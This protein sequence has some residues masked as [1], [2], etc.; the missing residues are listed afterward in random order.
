MKRMLGVA[1]ACLLAV[2]A[3][4]QML[5]KNDKEP[6]KTK[7]WLDNFETAQKE[8]E[9][10]NQPILAFFTGS[11]WCGWCKKLRSEALDAKAFKT[12]AADNLIL[13]EADFPRGKKLSEKV[14]K[15]NSALAAKYE[16]RGYPTVFLL[17]AEGKQLGRTGYM[18]GGSEAYVKHLKELLEKA[19]IKTT[20]T[21]ETGKALSPYEKMKAERAA[22]V[23][24][25]AEAKAAAQK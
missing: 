14:K 12:F 5:S 15:Q 13:F 20:E 9:A 1:L 21:P 23:K 17:D 7:G 22:R 25:E 4:A 19:G 11:D 18:Q 2:C 3:Q 6:V 10:F 8:A 24:D 16:V